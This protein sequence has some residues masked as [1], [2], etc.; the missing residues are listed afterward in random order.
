MKII[1][2][3]FTLF[4]TVGGS[5]TME[6]KRETFNQ[7][8]ILGKEL[9]ESVYDTP[10]DLQFGD[11]CQ[12]LDELSDN[13]ELYIKNLKDNNLIYAGTEDNTEFKTFSFYVDK[14]KYFCGIPKYKNLPEYTVKTLGR[15]LIILFR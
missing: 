9:I 13:H 6:G 2:V 15:C 5:D 4:L 1:V 3:L 12:N 7:Y 8:L 14:K 10:G 11:D